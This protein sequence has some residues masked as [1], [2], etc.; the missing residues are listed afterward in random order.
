MAKKE[1][2]SY[3]NYFS[4]M[5]ECAAQAAE[6]LV[7]CLDNYDYRQLPGMIEDMHKI[8]HG[9][10]MKKHEMTEKLLKEFLPP[11]DRD[12]IMALSVALDD[13]VDGI[14]DIM[15][16]LYMYDVRAV[17]PQAREFAGKIV[18]LCEHLTALLADFESYKKKQNE[19]KTHIIGVNDIEEQCDKLYIEAVHELYTT[20]ASAVELSAW[21]I[22]FDRFEH[23]SDDCEHIADA[24]EMV[25]L[26]NA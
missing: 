3:F 20:T 4:S 8:E 1:V 23:V 10:D 15:L 26:K 12:D 17:R 5:I 16:R 7:K 21:N 2:Y 13:V 24:V 19:M 9:A 6:Y 14:E 25:I 22:I 11:I 18:K